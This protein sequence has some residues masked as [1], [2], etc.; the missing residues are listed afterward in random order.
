VRAGQQRNFRYYRPTEI[1]SDETMR[2]IL[3]LAVL[4]AVQSTDVRAGSLNNCEG[5]T[6]RKI[7]AG[8]R[9]GSNLK[10]TVGFLQSEGLAFDSGEL[11]DRAYESRVKAYVADGINP[12]CVIYVSEWL[13]LKES[14]IKCFPFATR[15]HEFISIDFD[16]NN[17]FIGLTCSSG[18]VKMSCKDAKA[19]GEPGSRW[20]PEPSDKHKGPFGFPPHT[21]CAT[22]QVTN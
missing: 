9:E 10:T 19:L 14:E 12:G 17:D 5:E 18:I 15:T 22:L 1:Q 11:A 6:W 3:S 20:P 2:W 16:A 21:E 8:V 7:E 4:M 13:P